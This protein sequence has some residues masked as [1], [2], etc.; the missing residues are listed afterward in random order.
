MAIT[1]NNPANIPVDPTKKP[2][3]QQDP[4]K[5]KKDLK[6]QQDD[7]KKQ[8]KDIDRTLSDIDKRIRQTFQFVCAL[9]LDMIADKLDHINPRL[10]RRIDAIAD[11]IE[12]AELRESDGTL[13]PT[14]TFKCTKCDYSAKY[15]DIPGTPKPPSLGH[16]P[17]CPKCHN[18][19]YNTEDDK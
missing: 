12:K 16:V 11:A 8:K 10:A 17:K 2:T 3:E 6:K 19:M 1:Y 15:E 7:L 13:K 18:P 4:E 5:Q 9:R 14:D